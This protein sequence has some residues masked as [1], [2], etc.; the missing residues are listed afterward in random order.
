MGVGSSVLLTS[1]QLVFSGHWLLPTGARGVMCD[2]LVFIKF[3]PS[4]MKTLAKHTFSSASSL[5]LQD[6]IMKSLSVYNQ[7]LLLLVLLTSVLLHGKGIN[8]FVLE[9]EAEQERCFYENLKVKEPLT[10]TY[11][12]S[13]GG[14]LDIDFTVKDYI[15][16]FCDFQIL[17]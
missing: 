5:V 8:G 10:V 2:V 17:Y 11:S 6:W 15:G 16:L 12:V 14:Q 7:V 3:C 4:L 9:V 13:S 1:C